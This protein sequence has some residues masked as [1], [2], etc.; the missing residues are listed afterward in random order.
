MTNLRTRLT[1]CLAE[2][3]ATSPTTGRR[4]VLASCDL[5]YSRHLLGLPA[6][7]TLEDFHRHLNLLKHFQLSGSGASHLPALS[8]HL[9]AYALAS[10]NLAGDAYRDDAAGLV[11]GIVWDWRLLLHPDSLIPRWP[12]R[13]SHHG[14]RVG[15]WIG[16]APAIVRLVRVLAPDV[17]VR[18]AMPQVAQVL[19]ACDGLI[20]PKSGLLT[21]WR[22]PLFQAAFR[23]FY[24]LRHDPDAGDIG[25][26]A[27][28]HWINHAESRTPYKAADALHH[29]AWTLMQR[30]PFIES[31][32]YCL[33]FDVVQIVRTSAAGSL[34]EAVRR[35]AGDYAADIADFLS[36]HAGTDYG[37]HKL[38]GALATL[39][40]C[41]LILGDTEVLGLDT[42][43][44]DIIKDAGWL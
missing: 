35:R 30:R 15:H 26:I 23:Q 5:A 19:E 41:A 13:Y 18:R 24:R 33:D 21:P 2:A 40:E 6:F 32:P 14:W 34:D 42:P 28:L 22:S 11:R 25:G 27:H 16:G 7:S 36:T 20:N 4:A 43:P 10:L 29:R 17:C 12:R 3:E 38:P 1:A 44:I 31:A 9:T 8:V 39:H 37:L